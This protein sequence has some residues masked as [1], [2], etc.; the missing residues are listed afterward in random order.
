MK[1][2]TFMSECVGLALCL[3]LPLLVQTSALAQTWARIYSLGG[4]DL[5][6][7][8]PKAT[9]SV[10]GDGYYINAWKPWNSLLFKIKSTGD[11][12]WVKQ[13][14]DVS[15][16]LYSITGAVDGGVIGV[17]PNTSCKT[18]A[19]GNVVWSKLYSY[20][21]D[22]G[23]A[24]SNE[25][26]YLAWGN[27]LVAVNNAGD[28]LWG[29]NFF[30]G[31]EA[32]A[33][34]G[35]VR[36][37]NGCYYATA[38]YNN[39]TIL[40]KLA[41]DYSVMWGRNIYGTGASSAYTIFWESRVAPATTFTAVDDGCL[42]FQWAKNNRTGNREDGQWFAVKVRP[43]GSSVS[44]NKFYGTGTNNIDRSKCILATATADNGFILGGGST[45]DI[46]EANQ[47]QLFLKISYNG[48]LRWSKR[49]N[50]GSS[51]MEHPRDILATRDSGF[52]FLGLSEIPYLTAGITLLKAD[53]NGAILNCSGTYYTSP[54]INNTGSNTLNFQ[55]VTV[56]SQ[57]FGVT[58]VPGGC[59][60]SDDPTNYTVTRVTP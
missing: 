51:G 26:G 33:L 28:P 36:A 43:D 25:G 11:I 3:V 20:I 45:T 39:G 48:T 17:S 12:A 52:V 4:N 31:A 37:A 54:T 46:S 29:K 53:Q 35:L 56:I 10:D 44:W 50:Y 32:L 59:V 40:F 22:G 6:A 30:M 15:V 7:A 60:G 24:Y 34:T 49:F 14:N 57:D 47:T 42:V 8:S 13:Y 2:A 19:N 23:I 5:T 16:S 21:P 9:E 38:D 55:P 27:G 41:S 58:A 18:D 1:R